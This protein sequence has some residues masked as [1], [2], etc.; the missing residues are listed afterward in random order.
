MYDFAKN[1]NGTGCTFPPFKFAV[2]PALTSSH[3]MSLL[4]P[5][6][7]PKRKDQPQTDHG[8]YTSPYRAGAEIGTFQTAAGHNPVFPSSSTTVGGEKVRQQKEKIKR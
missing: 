2:L 3:K 1:E 5:I 8:F 6:F 4:Q 7:P